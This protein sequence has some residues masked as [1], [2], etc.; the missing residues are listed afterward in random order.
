MIRALRAFSRIAA[1][2]S[3]PPIFGICRSIRVM[4]GRRLWNAAIASAPFDASPT[5][6]M[7]DSISTIAAMPSRSA[8]WSS[9]V[10]I[11]IGLAVVGVVIGQPSNI[12][13]WKNGIRQRR[14]GPCSA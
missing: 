8:G 13:V 12:G 9:T 11:R 14:R 2:A 5:S 10:M 3:R 1:I 7:S 6:T 4:S